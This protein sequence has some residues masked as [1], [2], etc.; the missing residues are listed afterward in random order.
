MVFQ[1]ILC[2]FGVVGVGWGWGGGGEEVRN[3]TECHSNCLLDYLL[4]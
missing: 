1:N 2:V 3:V 4:S